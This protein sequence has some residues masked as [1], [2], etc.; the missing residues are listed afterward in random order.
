MWSSVQKNTMKPY[1]KWGNI[2]VQEKKPNR[3]QSS[4]I[5]HTKGIRRNHTNHRTRYLRRSNGH[6]E[7]EMIVNINRGKKITSVIIV[8][9]KA[10]ELQNA[11]QRNIMNLRKE[12]DDTS[13]QTAL[14]LI[15]TVQSQSQ[16]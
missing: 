2:S 4:H 14:S 15:I 3:M 12:E 7:E 9:E 13:A 16:I 8:E 5:S 6:H 10:M 11:E 1:S